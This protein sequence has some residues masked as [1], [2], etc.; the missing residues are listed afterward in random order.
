MGVCQVETIYGGNFNE[1]AIAIYSQTKD[2]LFTETSGDS[3][4]RPAEWI[5]CDHKENKKPAGLFPSED[6]SFSREEA[7]RRLDVYYNSKKF[8]DD[9][10]R[11]VGDIKIIE[12]NS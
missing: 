6:D 9:F 5:E 2:G 8:E 3:M 10:E 1:A 11:F 12:N 7:V 4:N